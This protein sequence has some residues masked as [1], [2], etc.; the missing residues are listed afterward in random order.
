M[1]LCLNRFSKDNFENVSAN[2]AIWHR[3]PQV[4]VSCL[5]FYQHSVIPTGSVSCGNPRSF[6]C[7]VTCL[8]RMMYKLEGVYKIVCPSH[9][10]SKPQASFYDLALIQSSYSWM[11]ADFLYT[12]FV[13][14]MW[15]L[16]SILLSASHVN[17]PSSLKIPFNENQQLIMTIPGHVSQLTTLKHTPPFGDSEQCR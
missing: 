4:L 3:S 17:A 11:L 15:I 2:L 10:F 16:L 7:N 8:I 9:W 12:H 13:S 14:L 1:N 6:L 5:P